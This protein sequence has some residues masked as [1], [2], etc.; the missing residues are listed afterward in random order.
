MIKR[1]TPGYLVA[2]GLLTLAI[3]GA[4]A[5]RAAQPADIGD[6][7]L[8][9]VRAAQPRPAAKSPAP[10]PS[11]TP[12]ARHAHAAAR[13]HADRSY[14]CR[15]AEDISCTIVRETADGV[16]IVTQ[17]PPGSSVPAPA[18][19]V[20]SGPPPDGAQHAGGTIYVVPATKSAPTE[21]ASITAPILD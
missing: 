8:G 17:R 16:V 2:V 9:S 3:G 15:P 21:V 1:T 14:G 11:P 19:S 7:P 5:A 20:V 18:W 13:P 12:A 10:A 4:R 6:P